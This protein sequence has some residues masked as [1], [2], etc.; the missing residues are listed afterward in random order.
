MEFLNTALRFDPVNQR[1][2]GYEQANAL[3]SGPA[4]REEWADHY[5]L[6]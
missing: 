5:A 1:L 2:I 3:L 6:A 4:P